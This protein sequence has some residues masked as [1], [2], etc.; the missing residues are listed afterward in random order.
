M[1]LVHTNRAPQ[2]LSD[3]VQSV[4]CSSSRPGLRSSNTAVYA[5]P[6]CRTKFGESGFSPAGPTAWNTT[7]HQLYT[8]SIKSVTLVFSSAASKLNYFVE[9]TSLVV[10]APGRSVNSTIEMTVLLSDQCNA[11]HG[12]EYKI[13]CGVC[14]CVCVCA[15]GFWGRISRKRLQIEIQLQWD[16]NRKWY[17]ADRLVVKWSRDGKRRLTLTGRGCDTNMLGPITKNM[18]GETR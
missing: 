5:K 15:H 2:Y 10:S 8:I 16:T 14:L 12:T 4:A 3:S 6:R 11:L 9:H 17:M 7:P 1:H 18:T 13:T